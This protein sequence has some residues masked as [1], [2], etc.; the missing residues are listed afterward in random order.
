[1]KLTRNTLVAL[2]IAFGLFINNGIANDEPDEV[3]Y[4]MTVIS[5]LIGGDLNGTLTGK[6]CED[7]ELIQV[8]VTSNT[9][10]FINGDTPADLKNARSL[11]GKPALVAFNTATRVA[12]VITSFDFD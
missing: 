5:V 1:M 7:C 10:F 11:T 4:E 9:Q 6:R 8:K 3:G 12:T 2:S